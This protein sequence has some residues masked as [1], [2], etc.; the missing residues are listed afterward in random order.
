VISNRK[1]KLNKKT[2]TSTYLALIRSILDYSS[3]IIPCIS[4]TLNK[5]IQSTQNTAFR[6]I[7][8]LRFDTHTDD[9]VKISGIEL[10]AVRANRLNKKYLETSVENKNEL[11]IDLINEYLEGSKNFK[12]KSF[13]FLHKNLLTITRT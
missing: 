8:K 6:I 13:L 10:V 1:Y 5:T 4:K 7:Y 3:I 9:I 11:I 12:N 2:L